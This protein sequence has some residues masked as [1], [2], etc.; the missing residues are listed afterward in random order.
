MILLC[1]NYTA[2]EYDRHKDFFP[3]KTILSMPIITGSLE[4]NF[5]NLLQ[6][7]H[8][9][10]FSA[11]EIFNSKESRKKKYMAEIELSLSSS[12][13]LDVNAQMKY[14]NEQPYSE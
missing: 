6:R 1:K 9:I 8:R 4:Q 5:Q 13:T 11:D 2:M 14:R 12:P 7:R 10:I 3:K